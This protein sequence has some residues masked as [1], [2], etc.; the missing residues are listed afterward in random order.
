M[1]IVLLELTHTPMGQPSK[2]RNGEPA[3][4]NVLPQLL[5]NLWIEINMSKYLD[6]L[7]DNF[8]CEID[9]INDIDFLERL[10][11]YEYEHFFLPIPYAIIKD[12]YF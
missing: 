3:G 1:T 2:D 5:F 6:Y 12:W 10:I 9:K 11:H 8:M 4:V 7:T